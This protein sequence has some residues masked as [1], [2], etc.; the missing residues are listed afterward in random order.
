[1]LAVALI[2]LQIAQSVD[3]LPPGAILR[4]GDPRFR[5]DGPVRHLRFSA[6]GRVLH[7]WVAG[8]DDVMRPIAW[9]SAE[10]PP[11]HQRDRFE[12]PDFRRMPSRR[13]GSNGNRVLTAGPGRAGIVWDADSRK[14]L[15]RLGGHFGEVRAVAASPDGNRLAT[16]GADGLVRIWDAETYVP[17]PGPRGHTG[18]VRSVQFSADGSRALT[19]GEDRTARVW[20]L[21]TGRELR[22]FAADSAIDLN[23]AGTGVI[24][25]EGATAKIRDVLDRPGGHSTRS[26]RAGRRSSSR[27][28]IRSARAAARGVA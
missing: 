11:T 27:P 20:D 6:D 28:A 22:T 24:V 16:G 8:P 26:S 17:L 9:D 13:C 25:R 19:T 15:A 2:A 10:R 5:A 18:P 4:L 23:A 12:P 21:A 7:G 14:E 3:P 1:M